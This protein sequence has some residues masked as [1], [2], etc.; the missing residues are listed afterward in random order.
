ME[1]PWI[2][3]DRIFNSLAG[4]VIPTKDVCKKII[5]VDR[6]ESVF[7]L[8]TTCGRLVFA[9]IRRQD[10]SEHSYLSKKQLMFTI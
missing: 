6:E 9:L 7:I 1:I 2:I 10:I 4:K 5:L 8:E 3:E